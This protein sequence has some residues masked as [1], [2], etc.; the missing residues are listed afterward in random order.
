MAINMSVEVRNGM[1]NAINTA[2]GANA[3]LRIYANAV[4]ASCTTN[5]TN[6]VLANMSINDAANSNFCLGAA[7]NGAIAK[8][9]TWQDAAADANGNA[10]HWRIY[11][12]ANAGANLNASLQGNCAAANGD[13]TLDNVNIAINQTVTVTGFTL[14]A[15]N[16]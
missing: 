8:I 15:P 14:T 9:G 4:P 11:T 16:A 6:A 13:M 3:V 7:A 10:G 1:L 2:L 5:D 12:S